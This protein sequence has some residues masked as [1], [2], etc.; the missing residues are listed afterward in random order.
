VGYVLAE[1]LPRLADRRP[2]LAG[3]TD[4]RGNSLAHLSQGLE[5]TN[6]VDHEPH[7]ADLPESF[8]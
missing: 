8:D 5:I 4:Q 7:L 6:W 3:G 1:L 2:V